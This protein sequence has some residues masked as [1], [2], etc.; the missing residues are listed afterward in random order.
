MAFLNTRGNLGD[1]HHAAIVSIVTTS[2]CVEGTSDVVFYLAS[3]SSQPQF[4]LMSGIQSN[5]TPNLEHSIFSTKTVNR[6]AFSKS[7]WVIDIGAKDHM[8]HSIS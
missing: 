3:T 8:I 6:E 2:T 7:N 4:N 5:F 1:G